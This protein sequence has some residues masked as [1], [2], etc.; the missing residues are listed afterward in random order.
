MANN[1][2]D[3]NTCE[4]SNNIYWSVPIS[5]RLNMSH[6]VPI[7]AIKDLLATKKAN[8]YI[9]DLHA[10][11]LGEKS[12]TLDAKRKFYQHGLELMFEVICGKTDNISL[13]FGSELELKSKFMLDFYLIAG[14]TSVVKA[15]EAVKD[16]LKPTKH[17]LLS[18]LVYPIVRAVDDKHFEAPNQLVCERDSSILAFTEE[19]SPKLS[20][21]ATNAIIYSTLTGLSAGKLPILQEEDDQID[22]LD[23]PKQ[24]KKKLGKAFCE[25]GNVSDNGVLPILKNIIFPLCKQFDISRPA[26]YGGDVKYSSYEEVEEDFAQQKL[27]PGD[28]KKGVESK[29]NQLLEPIQSAY[30]AS[31]ELQDANLIAFPIKKDKKLP[32]VVPVRQSVPIENLSLIQ[33]DQALT[34]EEKMEL[35]T[36]GLQEVLQRDKLESILKERDLK[37]YWGTATTGRPHAAYFVPMAKIADFLK[38]GCEVTILLADLHGY[39]DSQKAPWALLE[40]R[41]KYYQNIIISMLKSINVPID[42]LKFVR[43]T[44]F[45]LKA[46][47]SRDL[48]RLISLTSLHDAKKAGADVVKQTDDPLLGSILYPLL[49]ALDEEYLDCDAQFGG[50]DQ[51]KIFIYAEKYLPQ[52]GYSKRIHLMNPM[53]PGL[54]GGKMSSSVIESKID[55]LDDA[56]T[57]E[58]KVLSSACDWGSASENGV[59]AFIQH[60]ILPIFGK[61]S[62]QIDNRDYTDTD[63]IMKDIETN[64]IAQDQVKKA[65]ASYIDKLIAPIRNDFES[66]PE[67]K[68]LDRNAYPIY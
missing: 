40:H 14:S 17:Q 51:R 57:L 22:I 48:F 6:F 42:K 25:P 49:Q 52:I 4:K 29:I 21:Q 28:L 39:L 9:A 15:N 10:E 1:S 61:F 68:L 30:Q 46:D 13:K 43:G 24:V 37:I 7:I 66:N 41:T 67:L 16:V 53:V 11:I 44:E 20:H 38:A 45:E 36:R 8:V 58:R 27:H 33:K 23:G 59:I 35:I 12:A 26:E 31:K 64:L 62:L 2:N 5:G 32:Q 18:S 3:A 54:A 47:F 56:K 60:V 55:L 34:F 63:T 65:T 19:F 50:V